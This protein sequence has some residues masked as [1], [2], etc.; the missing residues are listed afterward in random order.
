MVPIYLSELISLYQPKRTIRSA[1]TSTLTVIS[2]R[3]TRHYG[4]TAFSVCVSLLWNSLPLS[5]RTI[6]DFNSFKR[7]LKTHLFR[8][9]F[10]DLV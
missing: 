5:I 10:N 3:N 2:P 8:E 6:D 7:N 4:P 9:Y 1:A